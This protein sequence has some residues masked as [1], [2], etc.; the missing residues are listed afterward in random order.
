[1]DGSASLRIDRR[2]TSAAK[3]GAAVFLASTD[4]DLTDGWPLVVSGGTARVR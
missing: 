1:M 4:S 2:K 3:V